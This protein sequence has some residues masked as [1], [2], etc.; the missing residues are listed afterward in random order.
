MRT[1]TR[2]PFIFRKKHTASIMLLSSTRSKISEPFS[3]QLWPSFVVLKESW[4]STVGHF[5][6]VS[7]QGTLELRGVNRV[8]PWL[9][10]VEAFVLN[11]LIVEQISWDWEKQ[12]WI[13]E[14]AGVQWHHGQSHYSFSMP[15][16]TMTTF[17]TLFTQH[18]HICSHSNNTQKL[19]LTHEGWADVVAIHTNSTIEDHTITLTFYTV[20]PSTLFQPS[21]SPHKSPTFRSYWWLLCK[22]HSLTA[23]GEELHQSKAKSFTLWLWPF[24]FFSHNPWP[25]SFKSYHQLHLSCTLLGFVMVLLHKIPQNCRLLAQWLDRNHSLK[26]LKPPLLAWMRG[27]W[28]QEWERIQHHNKVHA[29]F[30]TNPMMSQWWYGNTLIS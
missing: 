11:L 17:G 9:C 28:V 10:W 27:H 14:M 19:P 21:F 1:Q 29:L 3:A 18:Q 23:C 15:F 13:C 30:V 20:Q 6:P 7:C 25:T 5:A 2:S 26:T 12:P 16:C 22:H 4:R 24:S 8:F